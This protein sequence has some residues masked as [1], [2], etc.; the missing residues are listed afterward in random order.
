[1]L[2]FYMVTHKGS[3]KLAQ[4]AKNNDVTLLVGKNDLTSP[5]YVEA[6]AKCFVSE[7]PLIKKQAY[8]DLL[9]NVFDLHL[10]VVLTVLT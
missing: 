6:Q 9:K 7:D 5:G 8:R 3:N 4:L 2:G 10:N 1:M